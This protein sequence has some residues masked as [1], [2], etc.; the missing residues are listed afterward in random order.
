MVRTEP[1][2]IFILSVHSD[3][4]VSFVPPPASGIARPEA[5]RYLSGLQLPCAHFL[6]VGGSGGGCAQRILKVACPLPSRA[7]EALLHISC[8]RQTHVSQPCAW[9]A[10]HTAPQ[11]ASLGLLGGR[12]GKSLK[13][14]AL[15]VGGDP[16]TGVTR[17]LGRLWAVG[18]PLHLSSKKPA[19]LPAPCSPPPRLWVLI[20]ILGLAR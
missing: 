19:P 4:F 3:F 14:G 18:G 8:C 15:Q 20:P 6:P 9:P 13:A 11:R 5:S 17:F 1:C 7:W 10:A 2:Q 12:T 16:T